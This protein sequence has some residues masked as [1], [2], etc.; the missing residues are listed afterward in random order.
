ML[1]NYSK[2][3]PSKFMEWVFES[4]TVPPTTCPFQNSNLH[5]ASYQNE[6]EPQNRLI[7]YYYLCFRSLRN[8][9]IIAQLRYINV[10]MTRRWMCVIIYKKSVIITCISASLDPP[11]LILIQILYKNILKIQHWHNETFEFEWNFQ[12]R[13]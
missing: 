6:T 9:N 4:R 8:S 11:V 2:R 13:K 3:L 7:V 12:L 10:S 5:K 1:I